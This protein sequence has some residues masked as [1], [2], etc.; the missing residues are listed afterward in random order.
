MEEQAAFVKEMKTHV[1]AVVVIVANMA[2]KDED[3]AAWKRNVQALLDLTGDIPLGLY[4][5]PVPY[6]RLL[7]AE[8]LQWCAE[9]G[10][11]LFHK[12]TCCNTDVSLRALPP[13]LL[14]VRGLPETTTDGFRRRESLPS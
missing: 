2:K 14:I 7:D 9:T 8:T 10:R 13:L 3:N 11:F 12:D 6:H 1:D 4:E 5:C